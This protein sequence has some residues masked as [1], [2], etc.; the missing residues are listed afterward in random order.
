M[1][2]VGQVGVPALGGVDHAGGGRVAW[3]TQAP[4]LVPIG[5]KADGSNVTT[6]AM[7]VKRSSAS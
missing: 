3:R 2:A 4:R 5:R 1:A 6:E 7:G